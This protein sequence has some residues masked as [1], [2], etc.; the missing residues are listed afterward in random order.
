MSAFCPG[1]GVEHHW[2]ACP[3]VS[4]S[5]FLEEDPEWIDAELE[6]LDDELAA[7]EDLELRSQMAARRAQLLE[8]RG[9]FVGP[10]EVPTGQSLS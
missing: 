8:A 9:T 10:C 2:L 5:V 7:V 3:E 6:E 4:Q 1:C